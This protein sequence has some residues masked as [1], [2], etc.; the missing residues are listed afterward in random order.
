M[1]SDADLLIAYTDRGAE[2]AFAALVQRYLPVVYAAALRQVGGDNHHA[3]EVAQTVFT[4]LA[5]KAR[6]LRTLEQAWR[7]ANPGRHAPKLEE[8]QPF[9]RTD[10][11]RDMLERLINRK[12]K[13]TGPAE[14]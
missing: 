4:V 12:N 2:D 14:D 7:A 5:R 10:A 1:P 6:A 9:A 8:L 11:Q 3:Q 13:R